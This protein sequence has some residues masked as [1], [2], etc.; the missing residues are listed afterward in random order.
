ME[1][2]FNITG[3]VKASVHDL[4]V[5]AQAFSMLAEVGTKKS[6]VSFIESLACLVCTVKKN[7][8][9][10]YL[11][12]PWQSLHK[13]DL[14]TNQI[15]MSCM[16]GTCLGLRNCRVSFSAS[17]VESSLLDMTVC[18]RLGFPLYW[19]RDALSAGNAFAELC[20]PL[21]EVQFLGLGGQ[22]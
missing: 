21:F 1:L 11:N 10:L 13:P 3:N 5:S 15:T 2:F 7:N 12:Q 22:D 16:I 19:D 20:E 6:A 8:L 14:F 4:T 9:Q 18:P 17:C